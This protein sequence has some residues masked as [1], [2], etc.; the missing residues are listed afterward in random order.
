MFILPLPDG[1]LSFIRKMTIPPPTRLG[2]A[3]SAFSERFDQ[4]LGAVL[5]KV[6]TQPGYT[7]PTMTTNTTQRYTYICIYI[8]LQNGETSIIEIKGI[9]RSE[10][11]KMKSFLL[12]S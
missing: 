10:I 12:K 5:Q 6:E 7:S 11:W 4:T 2:L 9:G 8:D 1:V 3:Q